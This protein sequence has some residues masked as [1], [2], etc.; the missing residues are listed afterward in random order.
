MLLQ[1]YRQRSA[2]N[3]AIR[4]FRDVDQTDI[5]IVDR[6]VEMIGRGGIRLSFEPFQY[7]VLRDLILGRS[8]TEAIAAAMSRSDLGVNASQVREFCAALRQ[9]DI[10]K[11][12]IATG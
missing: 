11:P 2:I 4:R 7:H 3:D 6:L 10:L 8:E 12:L 1:T 9:V 5:W